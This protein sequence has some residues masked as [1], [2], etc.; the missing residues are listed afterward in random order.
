MLGNPAAIAEHLSANIFANGSGAIQLEQHVGLQ[1]VLG[2]LDLEVCDAR[3][4]PHPF[5]LNVTDHVLLLHL[6]ADKVDSPEA[7]VLV[8]SVK[9]LEGGAEVGL[10]RIMGQLR[11]VVGTASHGPIPGSDHGVG[12]HQRDVV[13]IGPAA[14]F[15]CDGHV[16]EGHVVVADANVRACKQRCKKWLPI[17]PFYV[18]YQYNGNEGP[19]GSQHRICC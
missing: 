9:G 6:S 18:S 10:G 17:W 3:S 11:R 16:G 5:V 13:G 19:R 2:P 15:N 4:H 12:H 1:R 8:A 7:G 14:A